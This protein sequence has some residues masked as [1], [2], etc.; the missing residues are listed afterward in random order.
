MPLC[1]PDNPTA[2]AC[3]SAYAKQAELATPCT[4]TDGKPGT[5]HCG[6]AGLTECAP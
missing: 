1:L 5:R 6:A 4:M 2:T 3:Q